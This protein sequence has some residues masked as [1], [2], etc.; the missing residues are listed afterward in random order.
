[1]LLW[2]VARTDTEQKTCFKKIVSRVAAAV[3]GS[4]DTVVGTPERLCPT[5][6]ASC[7]D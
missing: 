4:E 6:N 2:K 3:E 5:A 1:M 7:L